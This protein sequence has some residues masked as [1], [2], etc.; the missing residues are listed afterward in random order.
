MISLKN[1]LGFALSI[2][3]CGSAGCAGQTQSAPAPATAIAPAAPS[4]APE[5]RT[6]L[7]FGGPQVSI[8]HPDTHTLYLWSGDPRVGAS[9]KPMTCVKIQMGDSPSGGPVTN[10]PCS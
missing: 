4:G 10:E 7:E 5:V 3:V 8:Y 6:N 9:H 2:V 1:S